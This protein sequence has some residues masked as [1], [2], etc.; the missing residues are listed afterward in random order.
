MKR[1]HTGSDDPKVPDALDRARELD[2]EFARTGKL[3]GP[4]HGIPF[5]IKDQFDTFDMRTTSGAA[6]AYVNDRPP[7][8]SEVVARLRKAGAI[9]LAKGNMGEYAS[10]DRSTY[11]G[12][13]CN[14][15]DT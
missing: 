11:G 3:K 10:G 14:P 1:T 8:D 2:A 4:L 13:T 9:I 6:A 5:A 7:R 15:Y 12:T